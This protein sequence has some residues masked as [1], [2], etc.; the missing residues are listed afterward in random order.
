MFRDGASHLDEVLLLFDVGSIGTK[1]TAA[2]GHADALSV[3]LNLFGERVLIDPGTYHYQDTCWRRHFRVTS[4]HNTLCFRD[5]SQAQYLNRF[6]WGRRPT[7]DVIRC[8]I[9]D[10][11]V[12]AEARLRW[13]T[14]WIHSRD[15]KSDARA[16]LV[17]ILDR[18][19]GGSIPTIRYHFAPG[20]E[21][22]IIGSRLYAQGASFELVISVTG[23]GMCLEQYEMCPRC[24]VRRWSSRLCV[25]PSAHRGFCCS[26]IRWTRRGSDKVLMPSDSDGMPDPL[27]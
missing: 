27:S 17:T 16:S 13:W 6:M 26:K 8:Q 22:K 14:G 11:R 10:N 23:A 20:I 4:Q 12:D 2:H 25:Q 9:S 1:T 18:W 15:L 21:T 5:E 3:T 19:E 24:Y 7:V